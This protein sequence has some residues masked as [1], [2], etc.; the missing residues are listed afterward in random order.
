MTERECPVLVRRRASLRRALHGGEVAGDSPQGAV[1]AF[2]S[3]KL[4]RRGF[5]APPIAAN[6]FSGD[7]QSAAHWI[8]WAETRFPHAQ[9]ACNAATPREGRLADVD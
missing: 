7:T 1:Q 5:G 4:L 9:S 6:R 8:L 3:G 2:E